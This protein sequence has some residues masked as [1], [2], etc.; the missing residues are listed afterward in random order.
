MSWNSI[1]QKVES[2]VQETGFYNFSKKEIKEII[3]ENFWLSGKEKQSFVAIIKCMTL[4]GY[5]CD[6]ISVL[7]QLQ[8]KKCL[9]RGLDY[10][11]SQVL[12]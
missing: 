11:S 2:S 9:G 4:D 3:D 10:W 7:S 12:L 5:I 8:C 6:D 1:V